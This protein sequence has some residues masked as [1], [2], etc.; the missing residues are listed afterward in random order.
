MLFTGFEDR[1]LML[2]DV[3]LDIMH[4]NRG[5]AKLSYI[6]RD[7]PRQIERRAGGHAGQSREGREGAG[8]SGF[9]SLASRGLK[10]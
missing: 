8:G 5:G 3:V 9:T 4:S 1:G 2:R 10:G 6:T 7:R